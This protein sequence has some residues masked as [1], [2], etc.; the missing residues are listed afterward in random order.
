MPWIE[1]TPIL[2]I[3]CVP[4]HCSASNASSCPFAATSVRRSSSPVP[5]M[6]SHP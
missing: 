1:S 5:S 2:P 6:L 4:F 3:V